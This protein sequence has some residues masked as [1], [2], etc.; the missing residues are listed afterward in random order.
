MEKSETI[1]D[2]NQE[3]FKIYLILSPE[4]GK[5][6]YEQLSINKDFQTFICEKI[7]P[8]TNNICEPCLLSS[9]YNIKELNNT[10]NKEFC[11]Y[12]SDAYS[13]DKYIKSKK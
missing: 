11:I 13:S 1:P 7:F 8:T 9:S 10:N 4:I 6:K 2:P 5:I 12:Y 3:I